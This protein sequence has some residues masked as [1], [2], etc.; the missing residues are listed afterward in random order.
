MPG[1]PIHK[2]AFTNML[3]KSIDATLT[4]VCTSMWTAVINHTLKHYKW[5]VSLLKVFVWPNMN[6]LFSAAKV[7]LLNFVTGAK[8]LCYDRPLNPYSLAQK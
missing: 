6:L 5:Y 8:Q 3:L 2:I 7:T 4:S 1:V